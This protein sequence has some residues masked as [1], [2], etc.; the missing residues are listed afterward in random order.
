[1]HVKLVSTLLAN[2]R[3]GRSE[4][5]SAAVQGTVLS[6]SS[7]MHAAAAATFSSESSQVDRE[8]WT[9]H[10]LQNEKESVSVRQ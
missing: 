10:K 5:A 3:A 4:A 7:V 1:M 2:D 6:R 9:S 8:T